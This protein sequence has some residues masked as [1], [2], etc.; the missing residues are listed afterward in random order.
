MLAKLLV[1]WECS[2]SLEEVEMPL[3]KIMEEKDVKF[4]GREPNAFLR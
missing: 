1:L 3:V 4:S 2:T